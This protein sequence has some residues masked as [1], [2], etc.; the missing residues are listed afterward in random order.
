MESYVVWIR[1]HGLAFL[2]AIIASIVSFGAILAIISAVWTF[3]EMS[4]WR[5]GFCLSSVC[6]LAAK[7]YFS[8]AIAIIGLFSSVAAWFAAVGGIVVALLNYLNSTSAT[9]FGNHVSH[10][11]IFYDYLTSEIAKRSRLVPANVD[12]YRIYALAFENSRLGVMEVSARY[13]SKVG[14]VADVINKSNELMQSASP[15]GFRFRDHQHR[16]IDA[17]GD[18]GIALTTQPRIDFF[19]VEEEVFGLIDAINRVFCSEDPID[20]LP[21]RNYR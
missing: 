11:R 9:A 15:E 12:I 20:S 6:I 14:A 17:L 2:L 10:S 18:M 5:Y 21:Q 1:R 4:L 19:E 3:F 7:G 16:L 13:K 8:G